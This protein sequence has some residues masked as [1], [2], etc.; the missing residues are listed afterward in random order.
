MLVL[1]AIDNLQYAYQVVGLFRYMYLR[2]YQVYNFFMLAN[3]SPQGCT[4]SL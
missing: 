3:H 1:L 4:N 2:N